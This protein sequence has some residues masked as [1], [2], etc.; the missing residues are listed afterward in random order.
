MNAA[1]RQGP[2][3]TK[4]DR[5]PLRLRAAN[6]KAQRDDAQTNAKDVDHPLQPRGYISDLDQAHSQLALLIAI[7]F[8]QFAQRNQLVADI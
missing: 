8:L 3:I 7:H 5:D 2:L 6:T 4:V 1:C